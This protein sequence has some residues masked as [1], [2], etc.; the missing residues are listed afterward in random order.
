MNFLFVLDSVEAPHAVNPQLGRRLAGQL[1]AMGHRVHL[2]ELWDGEM[3]PP[4]PP[5]GVTLHTAAFADERLMNRALENGRRQGSPVP[6]RLVRLAGHPTAAAAAFRQLILHRPRRQTE[7]RRRIETLC[8]QYAFDVV[9]AVCAPYRAA[10]ALEAARISA[11]KVLWQLDPYSGNRE[12]N[13]PGGAAREAVLLDAMYASFITAQ[14]LPDYDAGPLAARRGKIHVLEFPCLTRPELLPP[15]APGGLRVVFCGNLHPEI[16][17]PAFALEL[18]A[19]LDLPGLTLTMAGGG[20]EPFVRERD[21]ARAAM[22]DALVLP[23]PVPPAE[24]RRLLLEAD[25]LL[26]IGNTVDNQMPSKVFEYIGVGK[27]VLHLAAI[28]TDP[29]LPVL[30]RYPPARILREADGSTPETVAELRRWLRESAGRT[31]PFSQVEALYPEYTPAA[32][33]EKFLKV[34]Q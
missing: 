31:L 11:R 23:G 25:V 1:A 3:P 15:R 32:V 4:D 14:A 13:A 30:R 29:A 28:D 6:L 22:G 27:P 16:R 17:S 12:Y 7:A 26:S 9:T 5:A 2:L 8:G 33:A 18:F 24:A 10:F 21:A 20:W 34:V 19:A